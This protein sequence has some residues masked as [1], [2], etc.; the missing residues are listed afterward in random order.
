M[1]VYMGEKPVNIMF[2]IYPDHIPTHIPTAD[3]GYMKL[4]KIQSG[5]IKREFFIIRNTRKLRLLCCTGYI[6]R[7][8]GYTHV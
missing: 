2:F 1:W 6:I 4:V 5:S 7:L 8:S 3:S